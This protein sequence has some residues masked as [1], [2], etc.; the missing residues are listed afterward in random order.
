MLTLWRHLREDLVLVNGLSLDQVLR[1]NGILPR[2]VHKEPG[3]ILRK[4]CCWISQKADIPSSVQRLH[5]PGGPLKSKGR[6]KLSIHFTADQDTIDTISRII[7]SVKQLNVNGAVAAICDE[8]EDHQERTGQPV[9]L[10]GQSFVLGEVKAEAPL[11]N[12]N[13][14][15]DQITWQQ[16]IQRFESP[17]NRL[18]LKISSWAVTQKNLWIKSRTKCATDWKGCRTLQ[19]QVKSIQ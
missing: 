18:I 11:Q 12:E 1:K 15:N 3:T 9:I 7:L 4:T 16:Y 8:F 13:P 14:M 10:V 19:S 5:C 2:I 17:K 6:G